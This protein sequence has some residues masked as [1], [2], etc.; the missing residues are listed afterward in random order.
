MFQSDDFGFLSKF[1]LG[2]LQEPARQDPRATD[3]KNDVAA[4][5][6]SLKVIEM[7]LILTGFR[8]VD[9]FWGLNSNLKCK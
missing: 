5:A 8:F 9:E 7:I 3:D 2:L 4:I 6:S 1:L